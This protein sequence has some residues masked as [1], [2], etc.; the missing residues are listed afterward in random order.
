MKTEL[1]KADKVRKILNI[2]VA[3]AT[4][5]LGEGQVTIEAETFAEGEAVMIISAEGEE[6]NE[7]LPV[8]EEGYLL[9]NGMVLV[10][11]EEGIIASI[12][13]KVEE[14]PAAEGEEPVAASDTKS[15]TPLPK[16]VIESIVKE[17]KFSK[18]EMDAKD[19]EITELKA[20]IEE[21][22]KVE[23]VEEVELSVA[24]IVH[25]P[26]SKKETKKFDFSKGKKQS[27]DS[28]LMAKMANLQK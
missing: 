17:T 5:T 27:I 10:V 4:E 22:S 16:A 25:N 24:P 9:D 8:N 15:E 26:E 19:S 21:L 3:L 13:E 12:G 7:P 14:E 6:V 18:E 28:V 23:T 20:K 1:S 2:N 11:M